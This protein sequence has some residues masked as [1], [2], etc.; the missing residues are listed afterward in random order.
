MV[1]IRSSSTNFEYL[2]SW[3]WTAM[4]QK[5]D[6]KQTEVPAWV[7]E[8][9]CFMGVLPWEF[10]PT[11]DALLRQ[12]HSKTVFLPWMIW[13][14]EK[15][16]N[17][18]HHGWD[19]VQTLISCDIG[20]YLGSI[21]FNYI[22]YR[23]STMVDEETGCL[24]TAQSGHKRCSRDR[25]D[26]TGAPQVKG[27]S[28]PPD[29]T[30]SKPKTPQPQYKMQKSSVAEYEIA[31]PCGKCTHQETTTSIHFPYRAPR[32]CGAWCTRGTGAAL[33]DGALVSAEGPHCIIFS[34][35]HGLRPRR[36]DS[37][38]MIMQL[39]KTSWSS[40]VPKSFS[41]LGTGSC[42][43]ILSSGFHCQV[44]AAHKGK[45]FHGFS[46]PSGPK[47]AFAALEFSQLTKP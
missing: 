41:F 16:W 46:P 19:T 27:E 35:F 5:H 25:R 10:Q 45:T 28:S 9:P 42:I 36:P 29:S 18:R 22:P 11:Q 17:S 43:S 13:M 7:T 24:S 47:L 31:Q 32:I 26:D 39:S 30:I 38:K 21:W 15:N 20:W 1:I 4:T 37:S 3:G 40:C 23:R 33:A 34:P 14:A 2:V 12:K 44:T 6:P 8:L